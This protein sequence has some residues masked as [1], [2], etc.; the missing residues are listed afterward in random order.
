MQRETHAR[1]RVEFL[2]LLAI[3]TLAY[4]RVVGFDFSP[5][6][7]I[8]LIAQKLPFLSDLSNAP[9]L[10]RQPVFAFSYYRPLLTLSF[11]FDA[12]ICAKPGMFHASN[13]LLHLGVITLVWRGLLLLTLP[14]RA[15]FIG[16]A[17]FALHPVQV[18]AIAW[19]PG[20]N[21]LLL[22]AFALPAIGFFIQRKR[23]WLALHLLFYTAALLTKENAIVIPALALLA[24]WALRRTYSRKDFGPVILGWTVITIAWW[25]VRA[26]VSHQ[27][28]RDAWDIG[29]I[30]S[31]SAGSIVMYLG[32]FLLPVQQSVM[33]TLEDSP[34]ILYS[35][36]VISIAI[37]ATRCGLRNSRLAILGGGWLLAF[38]ALPVVAGATV[39]QGGHLEHRLYLSSFGLI[40]LLAQVRWPT[41]KIPRRQAQILLTG[42]VLLALIS[43]QVRLRNYRDP[44]AFAS[45]A[46]SESP[47][48]HFGYLLRGKLHREAEPEAAVADLAR[49]RELAPNA[50][51]AYLEQGILF[52]LLGRPSDALEA[53]NAGLK[54]PIGAVSSSQMAVNV[55][56]L[57][58]RRS[59]IPQALTR[60]SL[61]TRIRPG[62]PEAHLGL[63]L[64]Y[65]RQGNSAAAAEAFTLALKLRPGYPA[66][67]RGL[68]RT[69]SN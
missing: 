13:L 3:T 23:G 6:D 57:H 11:M 38:L 16:A 5:L 63:G 18:H 44:M 49:A 46:V 24:W 39:A 67:Q 25:I 66:A 1:K 62:L 30:V 9:A 65:E 22:A 60:Y 4:I 61:A 19:I 55:A 14:T 21:D 58:Y 8:D 48:F 50:L 47:S 27:P 20:R 29:D 32:K 51:A 2:A 45:A 35:I 64:C 28:I 43:I 15:A 26:R 37:C 36:V 17:I 33:P 69:G 59:E 54:L 7:D 52:Q 42:V 53:Y 10:F 31:Q 56:S 34:L 68:A 12:V 40:V 41:P